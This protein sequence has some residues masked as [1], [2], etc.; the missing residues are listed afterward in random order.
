MNLYVSN[1]GFA[2][3]SD[4]LTSLFSPYGQ[5]SSA[6]VITDR[7]TGRSRGFAFVEMVSDEEGNKAIKDLEGKVMDGRA[8]SVSVA[9]PKTER[10]NSF[11]GN[12][13]RRW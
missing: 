12:S 6:K 9:K 13:G 7:V 11:S 10:D 1:L 3:N 2:V 4:D 8:I 5:V